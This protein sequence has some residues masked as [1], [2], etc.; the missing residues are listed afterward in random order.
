MAER[1]SLRVTLK[2]LRQAR[3]IAQKELAA[4]M[5]ISR[6]PYLITSRRPIFCFRQSRGTSTTLEASWLWSRCSP[7]QTGQPRRRSYACR[8][9]SGPV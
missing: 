6:H 8:M 1:I 9:I 4:R 3:R 2:Q 7:N 5:G